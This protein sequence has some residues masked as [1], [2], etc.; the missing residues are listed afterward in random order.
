MASTPKSFI[1]EE[2]QHKSKNM[3]SLGDPP[4]TKTK[5]MRVR[6]LCFFSFSFFFFSQQPFLKTTG[7]S[8]RAEGI[9]HE[10]P[11]SVNWV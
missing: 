3:S 10:P 6:F 9:M 8:P 5:L 11:S 2:D 1:I 4:Y 7:E